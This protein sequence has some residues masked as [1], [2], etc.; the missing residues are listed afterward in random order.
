MPAGGLKSEHSKR[1]LHKLTDVLLQLGY[2]GRRSFDWTKGLQRLMPTLES[3]T[4]ELGEVEQKVICLGKNLK[5]LSI[6]FEVDFDAK[7]FDSLPSLTYFQLEHYGRTEGEMEL[8]LTKTEKILPF[9][10]LALLHL[11]GHGRFWT[12]RNFRWR[13]DHPIF[14]SA[15]SKGIRIVKQ[16]CT[17]LQFS[18]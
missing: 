17:F 12:G 3:L 1:M 11:K 8:F 15:A 2:G 7:L 9:Y 5:S 10:P 13:K 16:V 4:L 14:L 18:L 6:A